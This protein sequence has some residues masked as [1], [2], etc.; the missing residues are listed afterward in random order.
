MLST[1]W[2]LVS[3]CFDHL[4]SLLELCDCRILAISK[5]LVIRLLILGIFCF[6]T[7]EIIA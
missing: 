4:N 6:V 2:I 1:P 7:G 3:E 5:H